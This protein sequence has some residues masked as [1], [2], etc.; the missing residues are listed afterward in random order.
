MLEKQMLEKQ[1][2]EMF[3][4]PTPPQKRAK[5]SPAFHIL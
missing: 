2:P 1:M 5:V 4:H 3:K